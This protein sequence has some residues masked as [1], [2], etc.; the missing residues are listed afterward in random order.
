MLDLVAYGVLLL[1]NPDLVVR[2]ETD[3]PL[4]TPDQTTLH[5]YRKGYTDYPA[6]AE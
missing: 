4:N 5:R 2:Y 6:M 1:A 3:A